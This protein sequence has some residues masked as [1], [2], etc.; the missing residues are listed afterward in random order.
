MNKKIRPAIAMIEL[1]FAIVVIGI[2]LMSA[3][4][5]M[6]TAS[7]SSYV[8][9]QQEAI[10]EAATQINMIMGYHWD[11][12]TTDERFLDPILIVSSGSSDLAEVNT[13]SNPNTGRRLGTPA[14]SYRTFIINNSRL[15]ATP[16][17]S[18]GNNVKDDITDFIGDTNLTLIQSS[19]SEYVETT[20]V[21]INTEIYYS[22]DN[23]SGTYNQSSITYNP[24]SISGGISNIKSIVVTLT[25]SAG[26]EDLNKTITLHAFSCNIGGYK[27][28]ERD[29]N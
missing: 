18:T 24:F 12:S 4:M 11:P 25:S 17:P 29:V 19:T 8:A 23:V 13:T 22:E 3:P 27:L 26:I 20:S 5:L 9:I 1:I 28:E 2:T 21:N 14:E 10:N 6:S 16:I 15:S 7:K